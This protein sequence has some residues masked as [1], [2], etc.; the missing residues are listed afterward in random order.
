MAYETPEPPLPDAVPD[1]PR[2]DPQ[3]T[4]EAAPVVAASGWAAL[5]PTGTERHRCL[6]RV[7]F[8]DLN[9]K[10]RAKRALSAVALWSGGAV[11]AIGLFFGLICIGAGVQGEVGLL[12]AAGLTLVCG[13]VLQAVGAVALAVVWR[14]LHRPSDPVIGLAA[15]GFVLLAVSLALFMVLAESGQGFLALVA[16]PYAWILWQLVAFRRSLY[17]RGSCRTHPGLAPAVLALLR[18]ERVPRF[19]VADCPHRFGFGEL[20]VRYRVAAVVN[21][22]LLTGYVAMVFILW[23]EVLVAASLAVGGSGFAAVVI[24]LLVPLGNLFSFGEILARAKRYH[25]AS[26]AVCV[27]AF[28]G[29]GSTVAA[30]LW[31]ELGMPVSLAVIA[32]TAYWAYSAAFAM[33]H[34]PPRSECASLSEPPPVVQRM[35]KA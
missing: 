9:A 28:A 30:G 22:L 32:L 23:A 24:A 14:R 7:R 34:L 5:A 26:R 18:D 19:R 15:A 1:A 6:H 2:A 31:L 10:G 16:V 11:T 17:P 8:A 27:G 29:Y 4:V 25:R 35:L 33:R 13:L 3:V 20:R 12:V 21:S